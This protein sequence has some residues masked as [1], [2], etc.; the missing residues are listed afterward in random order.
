MNS[1]LLRQIAGRLRL[2]T[3]VLQKPQ[4]IQSCLLHHHH[5]LLNISPRLSV[6]RN[7]CTEPKKSSENEKLER[8]EAMGSRGG[9]KDKPKGPVGW[10]NLVAT[11]V[12]LTIIVSLA[13]APSTYTRKRP[14]LWFKIIDAHAQKFFKGRSKMTSDLHRSHNIWAL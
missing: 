2:S 9:G 11:G 13:L 7:Y 3:V 6:V 5:K 4:P 14:N 12:G 8:P 10:A 1:T